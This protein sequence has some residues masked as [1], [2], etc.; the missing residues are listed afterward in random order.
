MAGHLFG[1]L[2]RCIHGVCPL[3][4]EVVGPLWS[5]KFVNVLQRVLPSLGV[6]IEVQIL[7]EATFE[8]ALGAGAVVTGD[9]DEDRVVTTRHSTH[10]INDPPHVVVNV[11]GKPSEHFHHTS[12][13]LLLLR[14]ERF[15][16]RQTLTPFS[17]FG[18]GGDDPKLLL[19]G[20]RIFAVL[21]PAS[22]VLT[23]E[24]VDPLLRGVVRGVIRTGGDIQEERSVW[25]NACDL[26]TPRDGLVR[27]VLG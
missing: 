16:G 15:P 26:A 21:V 9:V 19:A 17:E 4:R 5:A 13:D 18:V 23:L 14:V 24:L 1:P 3:R 22:V 6:T 2:K 20:E 12:V 10:G 27:Q 7:V 25:R 8:T 11:R